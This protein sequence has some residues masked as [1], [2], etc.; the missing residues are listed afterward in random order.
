MGVCPHHL[1]STHPAMSMTWGG[2]PAI[3]SAGLVCLCLFWCECLTLL[4]VVLGVTKYHVHF[5]QHGPGI[6][7]TW[8]IRRVKVIWTLVNY[9]LACW[10]QIYL[11]VRCNTIKRFHIFQH[12]DLNVRNKATKLLK[13]NML[14]FLYNLSISMTL[15]AETLKKKRIDTNTVKVDCCMSRIDKNKAKTHTNEKQNWEVH[16]QHV[17]WRVSFL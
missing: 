10:P 11:P 4:S 2:E 3:L 17:I 5:M 6:I 12:E 13:E 8:G 1:V 14:K 7:E 9:C 16:L 15:M